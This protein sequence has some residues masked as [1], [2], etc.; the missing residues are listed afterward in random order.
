MRSSLL[1]FV[2]L[3]S[4]VLNISSLGTAGYL[5]YN[6]SEYWTT[7]FGK[8]VKKDRFL[9]EE[10]SLKPEQMSIMREKAI[11]FRAE[12]D[13]K[14]EEIAQK[15]KLLL[16]LIRQENPD[17]RAIDGVISEINK[18]Q[19]EM[20]RMIAA[21]ILEEKALLDK[22]QQK[23]FLDLMEDAMTKGKQTGCTPAEQN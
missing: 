22:G 8:K 10:L 3:I 21:H 23:K 17:K 18:I 20:Q 2:L 14:R 1:K 12:I 11:P 6:Q 5:Y 15:R 13:R 19:E 4:L 9:F 16:D 7:P